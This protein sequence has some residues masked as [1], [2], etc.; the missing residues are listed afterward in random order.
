MYLGETV[1]DNRWHFRR[2]S[3]T[4]S[5]EVKGRYIA[6]D[7]GARLDA[8]L[9]GLGIASL[10]DFAA[11]QAISR[12]GI[13]RVLTDWEF[14]ARTYMGPVWLLYPSNRFFTVSSTCAHR[15]PGEPAPRHVGWVTNRS[16][17]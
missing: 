4:Q 3:E 1:D 5:V 9:H 11:A 13:V 14:E 7:A 16:D 2:D 15:L 8:A 17:E 6:N 10:P 12:G